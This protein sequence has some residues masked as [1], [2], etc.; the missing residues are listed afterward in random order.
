MPGTQDDL[1]QDGAPATGPELNDLT[2]LDQVSL[3]NSGV[4]G[5]TAGHSA[6]RQAPKRNRNKEAS[7]ES[8]ISDKG[9]SQEVDDRMTRLYEVYAGKEMRIKTG[10]GS[11]LK[12][13]IGLGIA[14]ATIGLGIG[15]G[16]YVLDT[17]YG[18][19]L[20]KMIAGEDSEQAADSTLIVKARE[21]E[22]ENAV[23]WKPSD[24]AR[25]S[26]V[27]LAGVGIT[28]EVSDAERYSFDVTIAPASTATDRRLS[29]TTAVVLY[30][31][32]EAK[33]PFS[34]VDRVKVEGFDR[35]TG[36]LSFKLFDRVPDSVSANLLHYRLSGFDSDSKRLFDTPAGGFA[37]VPT[38]HM[39]EGR[40]TW[41]LRSADQPAPAM[42]LQARLDAPGWEGVLLWQITADGPIEQALPDLP[43]GLP[44]VVESAVFGPTGI[45]LDGR[46]K[47][48]WRMVWE[49]EVL[50]SA[51]A[52]NGSVVGAVP[53]TITRG[54]DYRLTPDE[55]GFSSVSHSVGSYD[56]AGRA[57][58]VTFT[59]QGSS[60]QV[61]VAEAPPGIVDITVTAYNGRVHLGWDSM[62][63]IAGLERYDGTV[64]IAVNRVDAQGETT[65]IA[66]LPPDSTGFTD[67]G[68]ADREAVSYELALVHSGDTVSDALVR[69]DAWIKGHGV[70][71]VLVPCPN[72][73]TTARVV[74]GSGLDRLYVS[75][76]VPELS[77]T[78]T[79]IPALK[80]NDRLEES[81]SQTPGVAVVNRA[82]LR[83]FVGADTGEVLFGPMRGVV[84]SPAQV[85]LRLVDYTGPDGEGLSLWASD[86][87]TGRTNMLARTDADDALEQTGLFVAAL[88]TYLE[89]RLLEENAEAASGGEMPRLVIVGPIYPV[90]QPDLYYQTK[91]LAEQLAGAGDQANGELAV[92]TRRFWLDDTQQNPRA[93]EHTSMT[94]TVLI[95]GRAWTGEDASPGVSVEAI[96]AISGRQID[97][98]TAESLT[99]EAVR[100]FAQWC[101]TLRLPAGVEPTGVS[102]LLAA[103][104]ALTPIHPV[105]RDAL[106]EQGGASASMS[107]PIAGSKPGDEGAVL[108]FGMPLPPGLG[109]VQTLTKRDRAHPLHALRPYVAPQRPLTFDKWVRAY[110]AY[111]EADCSSFIAG[112]ERVAQ[113]QKTSAGPVKPYLIIR[114]E[115][116]YTGEFT[117]PPSAAGMRV[118]PEALSV[119][120]FFP[121]G[122]AGQPMVEY[123]DGLSETFRDRPWAMA[124][125]WK[126][127][128]PVA[129]DPFLKSELYGVENGRYARMVFPEKPVPFHTYVAADLLAKIGKGE[130]QNYRGKALTTASK[131]LAELIDLGGRQLTTEH[132]QWATDALLVLVYERDPGAIQNLSDKRFRDRY[133]SVE[134]A[135][136][137]DVMRM[138]IDCAGPVAWE[139]ANEFDAVDWQTFSWRST[140]EM[141]T[142]TRAMASL[143]PEE[144]RTQLRAW[145]EMPDP[146]TGVDTDISSVSGPASGPRPN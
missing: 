35:A 105:W 30:R 131:A 18:D 3:D 83:C 73:Q 43:Q 121:M 10:G 92:V 85:K 101:G 31:S 15:V 6:I 140:D 94:G 137:T 132:K 27:V 46:G 4:H 65:Q 60:K 112:F 20:D 47:G 68:L 42:R 86:L 22:R 81:L 19:T 111:I 141:D 77:Y 51:G 17:E 84:G 58:G 138:L 64:Q 39:S 130:G 54:L 7:S 53:Y 11:K 125:A 120:E 14:A 142:A 114:G 117:L 91:T 95:V 71:P 135:M 50:Q 2:S 106:A 55:T 41:A 8:T 97:H 93:I 146:Y 122:A 38:A 87:A 90:D 89:T 108:S 107:F 79:G 52:S 100:A 113:L 56:P 24:A 82:A 118:T 62:G 102:P 115:H 103:E 40:V 45:D 144:T 67:T 1:P 127:V 145:L 61:L 9:I 28:A 26:G 110:A 123:R 25:S 98:F 33:G 116:K 133:F 80:I 96:D 76:G 5:S 126:L 12:L 74:P 104:T 23:L 21:Q 88:Q 143:I 36:T 134:P 37:H 70:L 13:L 75:L 34:Q 59:P 48:R 109:G 78:G 32:L 99:P 119:R 128:G 69:A 16:W 139:W 44:V 124:H 72:T 49:S 66:L 136:Q 129:A 29:M 63:L 57:R